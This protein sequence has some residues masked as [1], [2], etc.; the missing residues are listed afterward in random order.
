MRELKPVST[1]G[2][3][4]APEALVSS[5]QGGR[6][7]GQDRGRVSTFGV[8]LAKAFG[9]HVTGVCSTRNVESV[10]ALGADRV[11]DYSAE[12]FVLSGQ[13]GGRKYDFNSRHPRK[14]H[15]D[16]AA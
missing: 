11:T 10:R 9:A 15:G 16:R 8:Q 4:C 3:T 6:C 14:P 2:T 12:D 7:R 1:V 13:T 5:C